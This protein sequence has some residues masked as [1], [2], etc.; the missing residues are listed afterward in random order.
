MKIFFLLTLILIL[1][2]FINLSIKR[3]YEII[4]MDRHFTQA[5]KGF[6]I[7][8]IIWAHAGAKLGVEGIQFIA[9]IGVA[10]FLIC[11]G[12]GL[13]KSYKRNGLKEFWRKRIF[14][15]CI[16]FWVVEFT[17][18]I[19]IGAFSL[20]NFVLDFIFI[21]AATA[22]G[23]F[24][25]YLIICYGIYFLIKKMADKLAWSEKKEI[26][27]LFLI[28]GIWFVLESLIFCDTDIPFLKARQML[29][30][31]LGYLLARKMDLVTKFLN[32]KRD[33]TIFV[34]GGY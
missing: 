19:L 17:G 20:K 34:G 5:I 11:S 16:P 29:S 33:M 32:L 14:Q 9:G 21:K 27:T 26:Y 25:G 28:F 10:L 15:V 7:L 4:W 12:Y 31:P 22:Y 30:F 13:E 24:M 3:R 23:W 6:S 1:P 8:T 18:L 2:Y